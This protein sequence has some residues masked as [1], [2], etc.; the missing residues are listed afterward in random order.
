MFSIPPLPEKA[1]K[2][3]ARKARKNMCAAMYS[4][5]AHVMNL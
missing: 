4:F 3:S 1:L 2:G 5:T